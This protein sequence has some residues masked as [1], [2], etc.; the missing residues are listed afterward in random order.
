MSQV[1]NIIDVTFNGERRTSTNSLFQYDYGQ[2]LTFT[3]LELPEEFEIDFAYDRCSVSETYLGSNNQVTIPAKYLEISGSINA[4]I[5]LH[6]GEDDGETEYIIH[7]PVKARPERTDP[8]PSETQ[9]SRIDE[10]IEQMDEAVETAETSATSAQ[11]SADRAEAVVE[12]IGDTVEQAVED[13]MDTHPVVAPVDSVNGKTGAVVLDATD[14]GAISEEQDPTVP[15]WAKQPTKPTYTASEVGA[16]PSSTVIPTKTSQLQ[17]DS[18]FITNA[19]VAS[20]NGK[21]GAVT[22]SASDVGAL[23]SS[24]VIPS[25]TS[26]LTNDSG[27]LTQAPVQSVNGMTGAVTLPTATTS[28]NGLMSSTDKSRLDDLYADYSSA[29][30]ALGV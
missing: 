18:G 3:D 21:T 5:F 2:I 17:N 13:Y 12:N 23:P 7:I 1:S 20:V 14:V 10:L 28:A 27:F 22:L 19:P 30:A 8:T 24:T 11:Q 16:L 25:K 9:R 15:S 6:T 26:D 4:F 29:M